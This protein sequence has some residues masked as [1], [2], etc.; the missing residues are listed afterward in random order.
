MR[1]RAAFLVAVGTVLVLAFGAS[2]GAAATNTFS[3]T[4]LALYWSGSSHQI[5][6]G[7]KSTTTV[8][9]ATTQTCTVTQASGTCIQVSTA[10][11]VVQRCEFTQ[12]E[13]G[14]QNNRAL[15]I[16]IAVQKKTG[17]SGTQEV[18]QGV[19]IDQQNDDFSNF[20]IVGQG[21][22]QAL[23]RAEENG[24]DDDDEEYAAA[25][26]AS[27]SLAP[28][29]QSQE[30][31]QSIV[32]CQGGTIS[33]KSDTGMNG[34]NSSNILQALGQSEVAAKAP[35]ITQLQN[36]E[37]QNN[38]C[39][40]IEDPLANM[41]ADVN[42]N[43]E[44]GRNVS[45][46]LDPYRQFQSARKTLDGEQAQGN[47]EPFDGGLDHFVDQ[48]GALKSDIWTS[49]N[50]VQIQRAVNTGL[51]DQ[52]QHGPVRKGVFS[53]QTATDEDDWTGRQTSKQFQ[54]NDG[55]A[56]GNQTNL[57]NYWCHTTGDCMISQL[58]NQDG[59]VTTNECAPGG[60][61]DFCEVFINCGNVTP[62][63]TFIIL[64]NGP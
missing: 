11:N 26:L 52:S 61:G 22:R 18:T 36:T 40:A 5:C 46:L 10:Q 37:D 32:V 21:V 64:E 44:G 43:T 19:F 42:Q 2:S 27:T 3:G 54:T 15:A 50:E 60:S 62:P 33:C 56:V 24:D 55:V 6:T 49:Q 17:P 35:S 48:D 59:E 20:A 14:S 23:G 7:V 28:I 58:V 25:N 12:T 47:F 51:L 57:L 53:R 41:C 34:N 30:S 4:M 31:H 9:G 38:E 13:V 63:D 16:Q 1:R 45:R 39:F 8:A 29:T